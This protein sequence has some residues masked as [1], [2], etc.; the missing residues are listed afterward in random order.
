[1]AEWRWFVLAAGLAVLA[2][3]A[4]HHL[5]GE[6]VDPFTGLAV[7]M[8]AQLAWREHRDRKRL[9]RRSVIEL[10]A[11]EAADRSRRVAAIEPADLQAAVRVALNEEGTERREAGSEIFP[12]PRAFRRRVTQKYWRLVAAS[13]GALLIAA[14]LPSLT[15]LWRSLWILLAVVL[16]LRLRRLGQLYPALDAVIEINPYRLSY[17][18]SDGRRLAIAFADGAVCEDKP[19]QR[20][21]V[22][23]AG[24]TA[25]PV[26]YHV[27][28]FHRL[29]ELL[30]QY[31]ALKSPQSPPAS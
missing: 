5:V 24:S 3:V 7:F 9:I 4:L 12:L 20:M 30:E 8:L 10:R 14:L 28:G 25:I 23:R 29:A 1:M 15:Q 21:L 11:Y 16:L 17:I 2:G 13:A 26:S 19:E 31:G 18:R 6:V 22:V 27:M